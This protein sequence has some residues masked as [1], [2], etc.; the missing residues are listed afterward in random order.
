[1]KVKHLG[2][3]QK[4]SSG[5]RRI[6]KTLKFAFDTSQI[7]R[8]D[9][10]DN[11]YSQLMITRTECIDKPCRDINF[12]NEQLRSESAILHITIANN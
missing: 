2:L 8:N 12:F 3:N 11:E 10:I 5:M 1:M 6:Y 7:K 4:P 9:K